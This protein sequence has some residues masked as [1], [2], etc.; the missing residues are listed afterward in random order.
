MADNFFLR[1]RGLIGRD[2]KSFGPL[3]IVPCSDIHTFMM[4]DAI[5]VLYLDKDYKV[6]KIAPNLVPGKVFAPVKHARSVVELPVGSAAGLEIK[7]ND[8]LEV[9]KN[10]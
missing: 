6:V 3:L 7:E 10:G 5:D 8:Q 2:P 4:A 9:I 1:L